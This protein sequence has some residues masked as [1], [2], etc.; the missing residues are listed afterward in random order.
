LTNEKNSLSNNTG[1]GVI[2]NFNRIGVNQNS[3]NNSN[4]MIS[5]NI[6]ENISNAVSPVNNGISKQ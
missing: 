2:N 4:Q 6:S 1:G 3:D 5:E